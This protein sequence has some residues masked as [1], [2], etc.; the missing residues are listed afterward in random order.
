[1]GIHLNFSHAWL[2]A[3]PTWLARSAF[4]LTGETVGA[5]ETILER[6][7]WTGK[8]TPHCRIMRLMIDLGPVLWVL[9]RF[10]TWER[11]WDPDCDAPAIPDTGFQTGVALCL[12]A[13]SRRAR[14]N[15]QW[16]SDKCERRNFKFRD[17][18]EGRGP[19]FADPVSLLTPDSG[20]PTNLGR[21]SRIKKIVTADRLSSI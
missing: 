16:L 3:E 15:L 8:E 5:Y 17:N 2:L 11:P 20:D 6:V 21:F 12:V 10:T 1:M 19:E 4:R 18:L 7:S 14:R 13:E 9:S